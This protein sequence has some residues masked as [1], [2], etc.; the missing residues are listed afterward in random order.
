MLPHL[1]RNQD[2]PTIGLYGSVVYSTLLESLGSGTVSINAS[3]YSFVCGILP[4]VEPSY[5]IFSPYREGPGGYMLHLISADLTFIDPMS[6][7]NFSPAIL[8][9][10]NTALVHNTINVIPPLSSFLVE[11]KYYKPDW[12]HDVTF[13]ISTI[14][15]LDS[16][17]SSSSTK[18]EL[19][20][21]MTCK[22]FF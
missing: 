8:P 18:F 13:V 4:S 10:S 19:T 6:K 2:A 5:W 9:V 12:Y 14:P 3:Q 21:P 1:S 16:N 17:G 15:I 22:S 7:Y 11:R 20:P